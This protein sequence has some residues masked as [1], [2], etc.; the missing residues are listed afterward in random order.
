MEG[1]SLGAWQ[2]ALAEF[3]ALPAVLHQ[4]PPEHRTHWDVELTQNAMF[5][6]LEQMFADL[7]IVYSSP[8]VG[9]S[10]ITETLAR[11][12]AIGPTAHHIHCLSP[13][14]L[15]FLETLI[16]RF[17]SHPR[18]PIWRSHLVRARWL[19]TLL[20]L[21]RTLRAGSGGSGAPHKPFVIV[22]VREP[23]GQYVSM[24]FESWWQYADTPEDLTAE[25][26]RDGLA[27][28][29]WFR[30]RNDWFS[31]ELR[32]TFDVDVFARPFPTERGWDVIESAAARVLLIRQ[33]NL[34]QIPAAFGALYGFD[35]ASVEIAT[36]NVTADKDY[37]TTYGAVKKALRLSEQELETVYSV[38]DVR[39]F[40]TPKEIADFKRRWR[41]DRAGPV[42]PAGAAPRAEPATAVETPVCETVA[43][44]NRVPTRA[45][46]H[47]CRACREC[48]AQVQTAEVL[49]QVCADRLALIERL[50]QVC[51][52]RLAAIQ[53]LDAELRSAHAALQEA[54]AREERRLRNR[55]AL[56][57]LR[58]R[59]LR[60]FRRAGAPRS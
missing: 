58:G 30:Y 43:E 44:P 10:T 57:K 9:G 22:A 27:T 21:N 36:C 51:D 2:A 35:P 4:I 37:A 15:E 31:D 53:R 1:G 40:Y 18:I 17:G 29:P 7:T 38:P 20:A 3:A 23:V 6:A 41:A 60:L 25:T 5:S 45:H 42:G 13:K 54:S 56:S 24:V 32:A 34:D 49:R 8:K 28:D 50:Q 12:P 48:I 33:E 11:H 46:S 16:E 52:E 47:H 14:G 19:R 39:H 55:S 59:V 26:I